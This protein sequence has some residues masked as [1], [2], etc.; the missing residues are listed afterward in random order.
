MKKIVTTEFEPFKPCIEYREHLNDIRYF[1]TE[2]P[3]KELII[4]DRLSIYESLGTIVGI[5]LEVPPAINAIRDD[6]YK[7]GA[8][9]VLDVLANIC[10]NINN[11]DSKKVVEEVLKRTIEVIS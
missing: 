5:K 10:S 6:A 8:K 9:D 2:G 4:D 11:P 3:Y 1:A 7:C